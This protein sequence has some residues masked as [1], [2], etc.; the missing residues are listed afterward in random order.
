MDFLSKESKK[1]IALV[2]SYH[3]RPILTN[4]STVSLNTVI[5]SVG[6][7][8]CHKCRT[9]IKELLNAITGRHMAGTHTVPLNPRLIG[10]TMEFL[11]EMVKMFAEVRT[12]G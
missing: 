6:R 10:A 7:F 11:F 2:I 12:L 1:K 8:V 5:N 3:S 9:S 4:L